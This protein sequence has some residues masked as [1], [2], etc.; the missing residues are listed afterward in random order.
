MAAQATLISLDHGG[1]AHTCQ[2][3][4]WRHGLQI[5]VR[6]GGAVLWGPAHI[7][8]VIVYHRSLHGIQSTDRA[9]MAWPSQASI[10]VCKTNQ[11]MGHAV[12]LTISIYADALHT[13]RLLAGVW[14]LLRSNRLRLS[15]C[16]FSWLGKVA[17]TPAAGGVD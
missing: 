8:S 11:L 16:V 14:S 9:Q 1:M 17:P 12:R 2:L 6:S 10:S 3:E 13:G 4:L 5:A 7:Q 15:G